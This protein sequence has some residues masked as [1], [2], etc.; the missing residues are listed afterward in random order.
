M[1]DAQYRCPKCQGRIARR[2][3]YYAGQYTHKCY[4]CGSINIIRVQG[5]ERWVPTKVTIIG[6]GSKK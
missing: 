5:T 4:K 1:G 6:L 3:T 2:C